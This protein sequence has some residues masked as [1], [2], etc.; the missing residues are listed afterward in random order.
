M[1]LRNYITATIT[2]AASVLAP[3]AEA[4]TEFNRYGTD[5][6]TSD[7]ALIYA[8]GEQRPQWTVDEIMPY[9]I[10]TYSLS[11]IHI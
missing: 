3:S 2:F 6:S 5:P 10:H 8:G 1:R 11:L 9:V 4:Y 7:L